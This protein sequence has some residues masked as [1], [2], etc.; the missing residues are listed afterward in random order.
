MMRRLGFEANLPAS[1]SAAALLQSGS[2]TALPIRFLVFF[3]W[4]HMLIALWA[5]KMPNFFGQLSTTVPIVSAC[6]DIA[7]WSSHKVCSHV[8]VLLEY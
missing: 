1:W 6:F 5:L 8:H 3:Q 7:I 2:Y 4:L